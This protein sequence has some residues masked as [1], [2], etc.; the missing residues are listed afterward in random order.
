[1]TINWYLNDRSIDEYTGITTVKA[2]KRN[3]VLNI[4]S[5]AAEHSGNFS[6]KAMN[7]AGSISFTTNLHVNGTWGDIFKQTIILLLHIIKLNLIY[8]DSTVP[9]RII[10]F[11]FEEGPAS[12]GQDITSTCSV[13][14]GDLPLD[15]SWYLNNKSII[16]YTGITSS[17]VG[18]RNLVL[19]IESV[20]AEHSGN[21]TCMA[22]NK[23]G[24]V[25]FTADLKVYGT[26]ILIIFIFIIFPYSPP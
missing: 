19:N 11:S 20:A 15:I 26:K 17:K 5:V 9:P 8:S 24:S 25:S 3:Q 2:G 7:R 22:K 1:M 21:F 16:E 13:P 23:A 6:C 10:P 12:S 4:E 18:K 14:E